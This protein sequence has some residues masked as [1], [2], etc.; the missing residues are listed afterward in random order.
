TPTKRTPC[1]LGPRFLGGATANVEIDIEVFPI[2]RKHRRSEALDPWLDEDVV[3]SV[4]RG[5]LRHVRARDLRHRSRRA[6]LL[7]I[8]AGAQEMVQCSIVFGELELISID[9]L[10]LLG[11]QL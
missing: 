8:V 2:A 5:Q 6:D 4:G 10:R 11:A 3:E 9:A 1:L 7:F